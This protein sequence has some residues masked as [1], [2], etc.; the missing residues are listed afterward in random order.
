MRVQ[1]QLKGIVSLRDC[2]SEMNFQER[3]QEFLQANGW[4]YREADP[5]DTPSDKFVQQNA[6][7]IGSAVFHPGYPSET[8]PDVHRRY[9]LSRTWDP[10]LPVMAAFMMN[11]SS[12]NEL[13]GDATVDFLMEYAY[14][15]SFGRLIVVNTSPVIK[16]SKTKKK[17]F[18]NDPDN[19]F[20]IR[21]SFEKADVIILGWGEN[22]NKYGVPVLKKH[23]PFLELLKQNRKKLR[24]F[25]YGGS[26]KKSP[27]P[28]HPHPQVISQ[29]FS[30]NHDLVKVSEKKLMAMLGE[31]K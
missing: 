5:I 15:N 26:A 7:C 19:W 4:V 1:A 18:P 21:H 27:F 24:V 29:R 20:F 16:G 13:A 2:E 30:L 17:D 3:F 6:S 14:K 8:S 11:P 23:H 9:I 28:K 31:N 22:G 12:A 10:N 25:G